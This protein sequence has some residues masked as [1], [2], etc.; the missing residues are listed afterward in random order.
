MVIG[1]GGSEGI[2]ACGLARH[3]RFLRVAI[4]D[5]AIGH[6]HFLLAV[7]SVFEIY[8]AL[9]QRYKLKLS[10]ITTCKGRLEHLKQSLPRMVVQGNDIEV[11][12]VD[13]DCPDG[14]AVWVEEHY[15]QVR[16][17]KITD[18]PAFNLSRARNRGAAEAAGE[19]LLFIDADTLI[20]PDFVSRVYSTLRAGN[21]YHP[22]RRHFNTAGTF[23]CA[24]ADFLVLEGYDEALRT[25]G[26]EDRDIYY[27]LEHFLNRA[28]PGFPGEWLIPILHSDADRVRF[29]E[30]TD[31]AASQRANRLYL[32]VKYDLCRLAGKHQFPLGVRQHLYES[33]RSQVMANAAKGIALTR[34]EI[35]GSKLPGTKILN[36]WEARRKIQY[37]LFPVNNMSRDSIVEA[38]AQE[39]PQTLPNGSV[40]ADEW[41][42]GQKRGMPTGHIAMFHTGRCGSTVLGDM[43]NQH[44][45]IDWDCEIYEPNGALYHKHGIR[46]DA[47]DPVGFLRKRMTGAT[48]P[49]YG[50]EIKPYHTRLV[51]LPMEKLITSLD[52]L[53][54][55]HF[56][57]LQRRNSLRKIVS[58]QVANT[59]KRWHVPAGSV[60]PLTKLRLNVDLVRTEYTEKPL[61]EFLREYEADMRDIERRLT[62]RSVLKLSYE[63]DIENDPLAGYRKMCDFL[64]FFPAPAVIQLGR[65]TPFLLCEVLENHDEVAAALRG[66]EFEWMMDDE[67]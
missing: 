63:D 16:V 26:G 15:P 21:Y 40:E 1:R 11:I 9:H 7:N 3:A 61:L 12:V 8:E 13:Y 4:T 23:I 20:P 48:K 66:T 2:I 58:A 25:W 67:R 65:T 36:G 52:A 53:G 5:A 10:L 28:N 54:F 35:D 33:I 50:F 37:E 46:A 59:T 44:P 38:G 60:V 29:S 55:T 56:V 51:K 30:A 47:V 27:R 42:E 19:W 49:H 22:H 14:T 18:A 31:I 24:R 41:C 17:V 62:G 34:I 64:G 45:S 57:L 39:T 6:G 43:L 32:M